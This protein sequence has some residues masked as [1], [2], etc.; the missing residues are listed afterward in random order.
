MKKILYL[1]AFTFCFMSCSDDD[2]G[3]DN[4]PRK[5]VNMPEASRPMMEQ[6]ADFA[7]KLFQTMGND[8]NEGD[9]QMVLSPL[10]AAYALGMAANGAA[11][12]T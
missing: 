7:F 3:G 9:K 8:T 2:N 10:S 4:N 11:G 5:D 12:D 6:S 1:A